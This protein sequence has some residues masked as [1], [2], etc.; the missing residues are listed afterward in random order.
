MLLRG[1][2]VSILRLDG[3]QAP[4]DVLV[5]SHTLPTSCTTPLALAPPS[6]AWTGTVVFRPLL[7]RFANRRSMASPQGNRRCTGRLPWANTGQLA[8]LT[9][10]ASVGSRLPAQRAKAPASYQE[11]PTT[12]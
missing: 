2:C 10:S 1:I 3:S 4:N 11:M 7:Q 9:H 12:G 8:A 5:H 6:R